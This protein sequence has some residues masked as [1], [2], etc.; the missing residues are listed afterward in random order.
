MMDDLKVVDG[1][2]CTNE[3]TTEGMLR[4]L[5]GAHLTGK[6][7]FIG[8]DTSELLV[9]ALRNGEI[10]ALIAQDPTRMGYFAVKTI[11][12]HIRGIKAPPVIDTGVRIVTQANL[13]E[14]EIQKLIAMPS[15]I[16]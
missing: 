6:I 7:K 4:A 16:K 11:V 8:F 2:F 13:G 1:V 15:L 10:S 5:Q 9:Q 12:D 3:N 14:P